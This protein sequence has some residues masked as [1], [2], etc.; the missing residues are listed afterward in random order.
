MRVRSLVLGLM[1]GKNNGKEGIR[2]KEGQGEQPIGTKQQF[3]LHVQR[4]HLQVCRIIY[5]RTGNI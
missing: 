2:R 3:K 5:P 4:R 1:S